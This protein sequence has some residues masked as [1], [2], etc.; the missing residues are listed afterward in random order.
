MERAD[1][2]VLHDLL[3]FPIAADD[4]AGDPKQAPI[5]ATHDLAK[6]SSASAAR[7][8]NQFALTGAF[9]RIGFLRG[10]HMRSPSVRT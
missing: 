8:P 10:D 7:E 6:C 2:G 3:G 9:Q 5:V 1:I 4:A